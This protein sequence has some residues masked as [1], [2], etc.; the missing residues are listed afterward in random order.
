MTVG[1]VGPEP[2]AASGWRRI[3]LGVDSVVSAGVAW[4]GAEYA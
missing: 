1:N 3:R 2:R 4:I